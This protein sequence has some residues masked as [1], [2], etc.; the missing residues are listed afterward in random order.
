LP[1]LHLGDVTGPLVLKEYRNGHQPPHGLR[2][3]VRV[4]NS[5]GPPARRRLDELAAWP[6][7]VVEEGGLVRGVVMPL[8]PPSFIQERVL[9]G[10]GTVNRTPREIQNLLIPHERARVVGMPW[11][12]LHERLEICRDFAAALHFV[13]RNNLVLGDLNAR[14]ALFRLTERPRVMLVDCDSIR[15]KGNMAVVAQLSAPD[16]EQPEKLLTQGSDRYKFGLFVLRCLS[17]GAQSSTTRDPGRA[18]AALDP[19]GRALI[20]AALG[21]VPDR[22]PSARDW[23]L[24]LQSRLTGA[25]TASLPAVTAALS[26]QSSP[27]SSRPNTVSTAGWVRDPATGRWKER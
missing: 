10:S 19:A 13:H 22:R 8:I 17:S 18:D 5:L 26:A 14:N 24:Y 11:P 4:R 21:D 1:A 20:R 23:G 15:I 7:R 25:D 2:K 3:L 16:W 27:R 6:V 12:S 9:P